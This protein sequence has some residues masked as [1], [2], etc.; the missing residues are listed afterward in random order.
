ML[1]SDRKRF[2]YTATKLNDDKR[3]ERAVVYYHGISAEEAV[4][5]VEG[6]KKSSVKGETPLGLFEIFAVRDE[7]IS[8]LR[9]AL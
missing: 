5:V 6:M 1:P 3:A 4:S 9:V 2:S 7:F 8:R